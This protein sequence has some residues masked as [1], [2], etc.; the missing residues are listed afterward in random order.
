MNENEKEERFDFNEWTENFDKELKHWII[1]M[2]L[3]V[4]VPATIITIILKMM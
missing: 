1:I 4:I 3:A 2:I